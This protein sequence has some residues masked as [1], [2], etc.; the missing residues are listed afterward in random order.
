MSKELVISAASHERRVAILEEGQL[1][2]IYIEREK[3]FALVGSIYKG[4]V[5]RVLPGMQSA[6]VDIG[7]DGDAFLYVSDVFENLEDYDHGHPHEQTPTSVASL[8]PANGSPVEV[9]PGE[10]LARAGDRHEE[11]HHEVHQDE[12]PPVDEQH[13][14]HDEAHAAEGEHLEEH[15]HADH[16]PRMEDQHAEAA[17][18]RQPDSNASAPQNFASHYNPPQNYP[19]RSANDRPVQNFGRGSDRGVDRGGDRGGDRGR[20][21]R[22]GRRGGRPRGGRPQGGPGGRNLPPAKYASPQ[23]GESRGFENRGGQPRSYDNRRPEVQRSSA[24]SV[25]NVTEEEIILPGE[26]LA[27][28]RGKPA[29]APP[30]APS[31]EHETRVEQ[32]AVE[33]ITPRSTGNLSATAPSGNSVSRRF[34]G[35]LPRWLL[36]DAG[37]E[38]EGA[39]GGE[40]AGA[41]EGSSADNAVAGSLPQEAEN[42]TEPARNDLELNEDQVA[43]LASG[44]VEA[45]HEETQEE[46]EADAIVGG[47]EF[48]EEETEAGEETSAAEVSELSEEEVEEVEAGRAAN[49]AEFAAD[50]AQEHAEH[51]HVEHEH[52]EQEHA[53]IGHV[54][55]EAISAAPGELV[56]EGTAAVEDDVILLPGETRAPRVGGPSA[57]REDFPRDSARIGGNPR[58]RFQRPFRSGGRDRGHDSR[59]GRPDSRGGRPDSRGS[60]PDRGGRPSSGGPRFERRPSGPRQDRGYQG[61]RSGP[62]RRPQLISEML[63][64]GQDVVIQIA[65]EPLGKKGAR[66][67]S[68]VALP[69]RFLVYMPTVHHT[70]VSR[71]II[72][73]ENRSRLRRLVSEAGGAY[74]GGFIVRTAA[75]GAT[76]DEIRTDIEFLGKTWNEI[77]EHSEQRKAPALLHRDLNLVERI[78]RDYVS[79]DFTGIWIDNEEEYGKIVEFVS[80]FQPKLVDK[81]KLYTKETPIFEEFGIQHELDKA[82]RAKVW[83]KSGGY[84]VINHTEALVA[85]DVNTGKFVGKGSTRLE[86]TIV[87]T[88]LEAVKEIVRQIRLRDLGGIIVVDFIDMEER[89]NREKVLSALQQA[90]E[91]D[92]APSKAL[93]F[94]EFGL[95]CITRKRTKQALERVLCQPCPYCTGSGMVKSIPTL[96]YE[97]QAEARKMATADHEGPNLTVRVNPEIAKAL[98]TRESM[99]IDELEQTSHKHIIIQSDATLHWEQYDIY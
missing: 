38:A 59:G 8:P 20:G 15:H 54:E 6:F 47:A 62:S 57:P 45:K 26:S 96:C 56:V 13:A 72:S 33:E 17:E 58:S 27:K 21:G 23:G 10:S 40:S 91:E 61:G 93:S 67:T 24:P 83:L 1:V 51:E 25:T 41:V 3:E 65:K 37:A 81:V 31:V 48:D 11:A 29:V 32:T 12:A 98:K 97:I 92:K 66:I 14:S 86:D 53:E 73:A 76:D 35:G 50:V 80:R 49:R 52:V 34:S 99:L 7:L 77:K 63:K 71:K 68:H 28:Y 2:E 94:N 89:R 64:A 88:N 42:E 44:F 90:L 5:T 36:A 18:E 19:A 87:K 82:L 16:S 55:E 9:L 46:A 74:P 30:P 79:D 84:I 70:G 43:A 4:K 39:P 69:G 85:I 60:R 78:L 95:V 75:G 22:W